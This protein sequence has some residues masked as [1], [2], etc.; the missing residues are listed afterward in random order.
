MT[1]IPQERYITKRQL[2]EKI[3]KSMEMTHGIAK[4][5]YSRIDV[6]EARFDKAVE[7]LV[8]ADREMREK[9]MKDASQDLADTKKEIL[10]EFAAQANEL[11]RQNELNMAVLSATVNRGV[12]EAERS[13]TA[14]IDT[15]SRRLEKAVKANADGLESH[16]K[17][18]GDAMAKALPAIS[19]AAT[20]AA[21]IR[22]SE[23][24]SRFDA[25][26][27]SSVGSLSRKIDSVR[28]EVSGDSARLLSEAVA[29]IKKDT[30]AMLARVT[31]ELEQ[32]KLFVEKSVD[33]A[34]DGK[35]AE[36]WE[37]QNRVIGKV[38]E[39]FNST[40]ALLV[41]KNEEIGS[42]IIDRASLKIGEEA[43][44]IAKHN[45]KQL[46][47]T[48]AD[49]NS[50]FTKVKKELEILM[51]KSIVRLTG[52]IQEKTIEMDSRLKDAFDSIPVHLEE[53]FEER[54]KY[55][56]ETVGNAESVV[57]KFTDTFSKRMN[58]M[59]A[60]Y[61]SKLAKAESKMDRITK[62][63]KLISEELS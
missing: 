4:E 39:L 46:E 10:R 45:K 30:D 9:W 12:A 41:G 17:K 55:L 13:A 37:E 22:A 54:T 35:V 49:I 1:D 59:Q 29:G 44:R 58:Q 27:K 34:I 40:Q 7:S 24:I 25:E 28:R 15:R 23:G 62:K 48:M 6:L 56:V 5:I 19:E 36:V 42:G 16:K 8:S 11:F 63:F 14:A 31:S 2:W 47:K 50:D 61:L 60:E 21:V 33:A 43:S 32:A 52:L 3:D 18:M 26:I 20:E 38:K 51:E 53:K 57:K